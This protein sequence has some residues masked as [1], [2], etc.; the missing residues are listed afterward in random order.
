MLEISNDEIY[1]QN[2][3]KLEK[4]YELI[5]TLAK[6]AFGIVYK[7]KDRLTNQIVA[8]KIITKNKAKKS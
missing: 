7:A 5:E 6:G 3:Q 8:V 4:K 1:E 2:K